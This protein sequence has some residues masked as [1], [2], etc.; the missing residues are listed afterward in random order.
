MNTE[1]ISKS[2]LKKRGW[3]D[4]MIMTLLGQPDEVGPNPYYPSAGPML[5]W[6]LARVEEAEMSDGYRAFVKSRTPRASKAA[7][8]RWQ[9]AL[10]W[11]RT[12]KVTL[13]LSSLP[14]AQQAAVEAYGRQVNLKLK[15][16]ELVTEELDHIT[17]L[18]LWDYLSGYEDTITRWLSV[19]DDPE[20]KYVIQ[21]RLLEAIAERFPSLRD[22]IQYLMQG[23]EESRSLEAVMSA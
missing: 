8:Q 12:V 9:E 7:Q 23:I 19:N 4:G 15:A 3:T 21:I 20:P 10:E 17:V 18:Y 11:A 2:G 22:T 14:R 16:E 1:M 6:S 13:R 5:R